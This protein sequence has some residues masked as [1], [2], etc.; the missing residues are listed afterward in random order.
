MRYDVCGSINTTLK[1]KNNKERNKYENQSI[2]KT[3]SMVVRSNAFKLNN[4][5]MLQTC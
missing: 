4:V 3:V 5:L 1:E 2:I